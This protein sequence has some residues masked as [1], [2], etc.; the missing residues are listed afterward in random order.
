METTGFIAQEGAGAE[1]TGEQMSSLKS[2]CLLLIL[3]LRGRECGPDQSRED[4]EQDE[5]QAAFPG[6][7]SWM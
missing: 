7:V 3:T 1:A 4:V 5:M 2:M 6:D